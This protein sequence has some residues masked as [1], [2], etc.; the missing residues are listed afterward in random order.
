MVN[1]PALGSIGN[2]V[3]RGCVHMI[4]LRLDSVSAVTTLG[5]GVFASTPIGGYSASAGQYGSVFVP[6]SLYE[7]FLT[8]TNWSSISSRIVSV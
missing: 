4:E 3:F 6:A 7:S 8:A 2:S 1:A 5:T